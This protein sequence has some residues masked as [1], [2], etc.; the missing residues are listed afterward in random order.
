MGMNDIQNFHVKSGFFQV[1][2]YN[3]TSMRA[4]A[5]NVLFLEILPVRKGIVSAQKCVCN[6]LNNG[7]SG[8]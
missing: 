3:A 1:T 8:V 5:F 6:E 7:L 2:C 4:M